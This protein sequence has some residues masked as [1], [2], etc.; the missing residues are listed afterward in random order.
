MRSRKALQPLPES[1]PGPERAFLDEFRSLF[2][3]TGRT[4]KELEQA[5]HISDSNWSRY[6]RGQSPVPD[7][8]LDALARLA[9]LSR[10]Q[11]LAMRDLRARAEAAM[12]A[13]G[14]DGRPQVPHQIPPAVDQFVGRREALEWLDA[15]LAGRRDEPHGVV[16]TIAVNGG[17]GVGKTALAVNWSHRVSG[18]FPSGQLY[19]D[20]QGHTPGRQ[21]VSSASVLA[22]FVH[23]LGVPP[24]DTPAEEDELAALYRSLVAGMRLLVVLDNASSADQVRLLLPGGA[25]CVVVVTSRNVLS[26]LVVSHGARSLTLEPF[27]S[28]EAESL[29]KGLLGPDRA[30]SEPGEIGELAARC[31]YLPLALR[32]IAAKL[33]A[34]PHRTV[35]DMTARLRR[36]DRIAVLRLGD[37]N[38]AAV[39][40]AFDTSY[41]TLPPDERR[42]FRF[43]GLVP[44]S[45]FGQEAVAALLGVDPT[46]AEALLDGLGARHLVDQVA[47]SR[48]RFHDLLRE[49]ATELCRTLDDESTR[50][51]ALERLF[52][53][54]IRCT[55]EAASLLNPRLHRL[56]D[57][58]TDE[59][60]TLE[61][62]P[63]HD[64]ALAWLDTEQPN[65][66]A[67]IVHAAAAG[68]RSAA[69]RLADPMLAYFYVRP[70]VTDWL[71][72]GNAA[73]HAA[74][75]ETDAR[76]IASMHGMLGSLHQRLGDMA[77]AIDHMNQALEASRTAG[78]LKGEARAHCILGAIFQNR[79]PI[80]QAIQHHRAA[81]SIER[82]LA[83]DHAAAVHLMNI[84]FGLYQAGDF[85]EAYVSCQE[86][87]R[88]LER[89]GD[90]YAIAIGR[91]NLGVVSRCLGDLKGA[92]A[93]L[94]YALSEYQR[95][96]RSSL[97]AECLSNLARVCSDRGDPASAQE[98][99]HAS[100]ELARTLGEL[101]L[102][103]EAAN[104]LGM[105]A[106]RA[107]DADQSAVWH[108]RALDLA[109]QGEY[110][111]GYVEALLGLASA[112]ALAKDVDHAYARAEEAL[113]EAR[114][115]EF[116]YHEAQ[117]LTIQATL[118]L[119]RGRLEAAQ[120][121]CRR[122][123]AIHRESGCLPGWM[124]VAHLL[125][126]LGRS[127]QGIG[128]RMR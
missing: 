9:G 87:L 12:P 31:G 39:R 128:R 100:L 124:E 119:E 64:S 115:A 15:Q 121:A 66:V 59:L 74:I 41:D 47:G 29:L 44:G 63:D 67:M 54:Y 105:V 83:D 2:Q 99:A 114:Q 45:D 88:I 5:T 109:A 46:A 82:R 60:G 103:A 27:S 35:A 122:A 95:T 62:M 3:R 73:L 116:R 49:Y 19:A 102:E 110:V 70:S 76:A 96:S 26:E 14:D 89:M 40:A 30:G 32:I 84:G 68:P 97:E 79:G 52:A 80:G 93:D 91:D 104:T 111:R 55:N 13:G 113:A 50:R 48:Y 98:H 42:A 126:S 85:A 106:R 23:A 125:A 11:W 78:W 38:N 69:W 101:R 43:L 127:S 58:G 81:L 123:R 92:T 75:G 22:R 28:D 25:G 51:E 21:P 61:P 4:L 108:G 94:H 16:T 117:A 17:A 20:L 1:L 37:S 90:E 57:E 24:N 56:P 112:A 36:P 18:R 53:Y 8:A 120:D 65:L 107:G 7:Q 118:L 77:V 10:S 6:L 71:L 33:Q 34:E 72:V 86:A